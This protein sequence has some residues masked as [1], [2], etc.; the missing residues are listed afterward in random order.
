M[1]IYIDGQEKQVDVAAGVA[2]PVGSI[3]PPN[4]IYIGHD[5]IQSIDELQISNMVEPSTQSIWNQW[6]LWA[7]I[8]V[9]AGIGVMLYLKN[10]G[11]LSLSK[12]KL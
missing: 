5:S 1:H 8:F 7:I 6:W 11:L 3:E 2:N 9:G 12:T 10:R 4:E